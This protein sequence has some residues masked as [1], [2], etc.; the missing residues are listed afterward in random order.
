[1]T[2]A[3]RLSRFTATVDRPAAEIELDAA[4]LYIGDWDDDTIDVARARA[5]LDRIA[6]LVAQR[7]ATGDLPWAGARAIALTLFTDLG[8]RGNSADYYDP[9]NSFLSQVMARRTGIP[10]TLS[11]LYLEVAR[12]A[13][14]DAR[15]VGFPGHFLVRVHE[16][17]AALVV[18]PFNGG[19]ALAPADLEAL[20][21]KIGGGEAKID[22]ALLAEATKP[23][24]LARM[25][26]NLA[27]I[28]GKQGDLFRSLE[29]LE[30]LHVLDRENPR[31]ARDLEQL[32]SRVSALN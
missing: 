2:Q 5:E 15:G 9:R 3:S 20:I 6:G 8:Y 17:G 21:K 26:L 18:D 7:A 10:I 29:V 25:L 1:M 4:A 23:Q 16:D 24:I 28:Y 14:I 32:R 12:R 27:G 11:V 13:G 30:R 22:D 31:L 19:A